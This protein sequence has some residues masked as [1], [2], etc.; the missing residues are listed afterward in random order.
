MTSITCNRDFH[1]YQNVKTLF[2]AKS[3]Y[4]LGTDDD[5]LHLCCGQRRKGCVSE[6]KIAG[7]GGNGKE[8]AAINAA[9]AKKQTCPHTMGRVS[10]VRRQKEMAIKDRLLLWRINRLH[11][12]ATWSS[13]DA[14]QRWIQA[15][16]LLAEDGL[17]PEDGN[18]EAN[19]RVFNIVMGPEHSGRV[20]TQGFGVTPTRYFPHSTNEG[21]SS[22]GSN[23]SEIVNLREEVN[24]LR[25]EMRE[26]MQQFRMQ[27][28][29]PQGSSQMLGFQGGNGIG[30]S[31]IYL[32]AIS[33][34]LLLA[35]VLLVA[36]MSVAMLYLCS[37]LNRFYVRCVY[38]SASKTAA[39]CL[40]STLQSQRYCS[41]YG[42]A[43]RSV[44]LLASELY[45][46]PQRAVCFCSQVNYSVYATCCLLLLIGGLCNASFVTTCG[47]KVDNQKPPSIVCK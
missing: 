40:C 12:D 32:C 47:Q 25:T 6:R 18:V 39:K 28:H 17:T 3:L 5:F 27:Q 34:E 37:D 21:R 30:S 9:N 16:E 33:E 13:E 2:N 20:R 22:G 31:S 35:D 46:S 8:R 1:G 42:T 23:L 29:P 11:K 4:W 7:E 15:C 14:K 44:L 36:V 41:G 24:S 43:A 19:E 45:C 38:P 26:F 10:S